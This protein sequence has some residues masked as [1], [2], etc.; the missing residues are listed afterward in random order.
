[1]RAC[2]EARSTIERTASLQQQAGR[3][4]YLLI[5]DLSI[6][7]L[8]VAG[9]RP[10]PSGGAWLPSPC[11]R[12]PPPRPCR[13]SCCSPAPSPAA[14][15]PRPSQLRPP[16]H[17]RHRPPPR[18]PAR[19]HACVCAERRAPRP[20]PHSAGCRVCCGSPAPAHAIHPPST[21]V[22]LVYPSSASICA[23]RCARGPALHACG[24]RG[25]APQRGG[26]VGSERKRLAQDDHLRALP[27]VTVSRALSVS[28][29][30]P[31]LR[32]ASKPAAQQKRVSAKRGACPAT[33]RR[34]PR[35]RHGTRCAPRGWP[36]PCPGSACGPRPG[37]ASSGSCPPRL[38]VRV[39]TRKQERSDATSF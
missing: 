9:G 28:P 18:R 31:P 17:G 6:Y 5:A 3:Q 39:R 8:L 7:L 11:A 27:I 16:H 25:R 21:S 34:A 38:R 2:S 14:P 1:M 37:T 15:P 36:R 19:L 4:V 32:T 12:P 26:G 24:R 10:P 13:S 20:S 33:L 29:R 30:S 22:R 23:A 35:W